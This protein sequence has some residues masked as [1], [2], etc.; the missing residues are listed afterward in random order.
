MTQLKGQPLRSVIYITAVPLDDDS[1]GGNICCRNH[2]RRL[3]DDPGIQLFVIAIVNP[4]REAATSRYLSDLGVAHTIAVPVGD[5]VHQ[6]GQTLRAT[7]GLGWRVMTQYPWELRSMNQLAIDR[8]IF[9]IVTRRKPDWVVIDYLF[10]ALFCE[11][12]FGANARVAIVTLNQEAAFYKQMITLGLISHDPWAARL[13]AHRL[14][15]KERQLYNAC[16][17]LIAIG[18]SDIPKHFVA[19]KGVCI[20]PFLEPKAVAWRYVQDSASEV[21]FVGNIAHYPNRLAIEYIATKLAPEVSKRRHDIRF[22]VVGASRADVATAWHHPQID[23]LGIGTAETV[24]RLFRTAGLFICPVANEFGMK[25]KV[26][27]AIAYGIP[28]CVTPQVHKCIAYAP[29]VPAIGLEQVDFA[30]QTLCELAGNEAALTTLS[31]AMTRE[32]DAF[33]LQQ[34][35]VWSRTLD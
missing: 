22:K 4:G 7:L 8:F 3:K 13:S 25:F 27:E 2:V 6:V 19:N 9:G 17:K 29:S 33:M 26:A 12:V 16:D 14:A 5:N 31:G 1:N 28:S 35:G 32:R 18:A 30:A 23:Y 24:D 11:S 21:F 15:R 34:L 10:S 20:T